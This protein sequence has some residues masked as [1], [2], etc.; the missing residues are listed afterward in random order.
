MII[1]DPF[2]GKEAEFGI[3]AEVKFPSRSPSPQREK[4]DLNMNFDEL[5]FIEDDVDIDKIAE[6]K[7]E[8]ELK[9][10][11]DDAEAKRAALVL[12]I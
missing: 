8:E 1:D 6:K 7:T 9:Q 10:E 12:E 2:E 3:K 5:E 4:I 11:K